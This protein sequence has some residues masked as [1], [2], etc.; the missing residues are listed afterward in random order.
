[1]DRTQQ[2]H[3]KELQPVT[4]GDMQAIQKAKTGAQSCVFHQG[5]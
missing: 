1:M 2:Q 3:F 5:G 4:E